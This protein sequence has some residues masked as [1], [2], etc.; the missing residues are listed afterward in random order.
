MLTTIEMG[1]DGVHRSGVTGPKSKLLEQILSF[2]LPI[3]LNT[4][5]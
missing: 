4:A 3:S 5:S 2:K 1:M